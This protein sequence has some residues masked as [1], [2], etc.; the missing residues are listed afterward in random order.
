[1]STLYIPKI[2]KKSEGIEY[3]VKVHSL[4]QQMKL[5]EEN[6]KDLFSNR[7]EEP[8]N[9]HDAFLLYRGKIS[10]RI[11]DYTSLLTQCDEILN[12][13]NKE[14]E[15]DIQDRYVYHTQNLKKYKQELTIW[16]ANH[17][18]D[19]HRLCL[20]L[21]LDPKKVESLRSAGE[22]PEK[23]K[24]NMNL[25]DTKKMMIEEV[26]RMK[27]VKS[28]LLESSD[29][30]KKQDATFNTFEDKIK[31]SGRLLLSLKKKAETDTKYVWYSFF[32]FLSVCIYIILRRLGF[33][34]A[35]VTVAR[36]MFSILFYLFKYTFKLFS[37][38]QNKRQSEIKI[39][40][41]PTLVTDETF[42]ST[43][44]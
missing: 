38:F 2:N 3:N 12:S 8:Y 18:N 32:F 17:E 15:K 20:K 44:L 36:M 30:L 7:G 21:F 35:I 4:F 40:E 43:E 6:L 31:S 10:K 26:N 24:S 1:M 34:R 22:D 27:Y 9:D 37:I 14:K 42:V 41:T 13:Q 28:E 16:W 29:K 11:I 19:Y 39:I 23:I 33:I 25:E 5:I